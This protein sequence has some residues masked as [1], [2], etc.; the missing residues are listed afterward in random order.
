M[1]ELPDLIEAL[2]EP[3]TYPDPPRKVELIQTQISYIF[4]A[5]EYVYKI[6]KPVDMGFLDYTTLEKR[7]FYCQREVELNRRLCAYAYLDVVPIV[8]QEG[9]YLVGKKGVPV[10]YAV[11]MRRLPQDAMMDVLLTKNK[12]TSEMVAE[13]AKVVAN[14]HKKAATSEEIS[15]TGG[16]EAVIKNTS[17]NFAQ[18]DK[19]FS[20]IIEPATYLRIK[21]YTEGFIKNNT[22]LFRKRMAERR[23]RDCHGDLH[24]G[25]ICF[26]KNG[27]CIYDCIEF[28]DR[29][30]YTDVAADV[31]FLAM[32]LDH[33]GRPDLSE[34]FVKTYNRESDDKELMKLL[35]FY[36]C[37]RA[38][39][40]G[41]VS[42]FQ[43][44]DPQIPAA[45]K[46]KIKASAQRY[47]KLAESYVDK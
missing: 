37:Y 22:A 17:E 1:S 9:W 33:Y 7:L 16:I 19:Y 15:R 8:K 30:R 44:D 26:L 4:L 45:E 18:T 46:E 25:H 23:V 47:F 2:L 43:Y 40:R 28:I 14:F 39:V 10:E 24:A 5:G 36:K 32:D 11:K 38:Y 12:V 20:V 34:I 41:K 21:A 35:N 27:I 13:V 3:R 31:A 6:K 29:L 42:C